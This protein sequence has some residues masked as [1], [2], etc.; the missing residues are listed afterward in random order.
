MEKDF[1]LWNIKKKEIHK[2]T[3][4]P[5]CYPRE[6]WWC[7]IGANI[8]AE[9]DGKNDNFER[10]VLIFRVY[11]KETFLALPITSQEKK[12][13]FHCAVKVK[14][15]I[16]WVKLTQARVISNRRLLRKVDVLSIGEFGKV[17]KAFQNYI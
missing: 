3:S 12:D 9:T 4:A 2:Q 14:I 11:N 7:A 8:G 15:G 5:F 10:P 6:V 17:Q 16:V 13:I 1:D